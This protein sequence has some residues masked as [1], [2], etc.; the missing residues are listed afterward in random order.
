MYIR[1]EL[2]RFAESMEIKL[3]QNDFKEAWGLCAISYLFGQL[4]E[5]VHELH[6]AIND[7]DVQKIIDECVDVAN[8]AMMIADN[9][10]PKEHRENHPKHVMPELEKL[11]LVY[12]VNFKEI[13]DWTEKYKLNNRSAVGPAFRELLTIVLRIKSDLVP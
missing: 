13:L 9:H 12:E 3:K 6:V 7:G 8:Y 5:E 10:S 2:L 1:T 4:K 11:L